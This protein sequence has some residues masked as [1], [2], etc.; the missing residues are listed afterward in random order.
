MDAD[1][2]QAL[3]EGITRHSQPKLSEGSEVE[4]DEGLTIFSGSELQTAT[5]ILTALSKRKFVGITSYVE[6]SKA[7]RSLSIECSI[8]RIGVNYNRNDKIND[9]RPKISIERQ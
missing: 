6:I 2:R 5:R 4:G 1:I 3:L 9:G 8:A 7:S